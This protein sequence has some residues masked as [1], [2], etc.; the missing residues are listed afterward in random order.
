[1]KSSIFLSDKSIEDIFLSLIYLAILSSV[2]NQYGRVTANS[3]FNTS[4]RAKWQ[5]KFDFLHLMSA[6]QDQV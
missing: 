2:V 3:R 6:A 5:K 4:E 1:M